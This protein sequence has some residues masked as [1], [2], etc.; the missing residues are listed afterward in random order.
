M[1]MMGGGMGGGFR[2]VP[3]T[4]LP[5]ANL[6]PNQ[7]RHLP[8]R[9]VSLSQ[10][11]PDAENPV[12]LPPKGEKLQLG[13]I[14]QVTDDA[15][16][17]KAMKRLAE[18]KAPLSVAQV[19]MW[20]VKDGMGWDEIARVAKGAVNAYELTLAR[21][22]VKQLDN[23]PP[24]D[25]GAL[26][27]QVGA[28]DPANQPV[29]DALGKLLQEK[30]VLGLPARAGVPDRPEGPSVACRI[31]VIGTAAKPEAVVQVA[32][33]DANAQSWVP[34]GKFNLPVEREKGEVKAVQ[35][36]DALAGEILD[37]LVRAQLSK[38]PMVK[39]KQV[40]KV[41]IDNSSP[42]ILNGLAVLGASPKEGE[43]PKILSGISVAPS[44]KMTVPAT[45][46]MV[47]QLGLRKG[48]RVIAADLSGL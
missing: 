33:S 43:A 1:G 16:V 19:V 48:V 13:D 46:E 29:A 9:L 17:Q 14:S 20:R 10:P 6:K 5:F 8:T 2:S 18:D 26:L 31:Q 41:Q 42:L 15:R 3:P 28:A 47:D 25:T 32:K 37:R 22:F 23:L 39:G 30:Y 36:V 21:H 11:N 38:G 40:Y 34:V 12:A 44:K 27:Y 24:D 4:D 45:S 7:T 35:F